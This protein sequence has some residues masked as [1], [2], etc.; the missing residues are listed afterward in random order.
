MSLDV[1]GVKIDRLSHEQVSDSLR[2][3]LLGVEQK[4]VVT[5]NPEFVLAAQDD[6]RFREILNEAHLSL[7][8]G[9]GLR[10][11]VSAIHDEDLEHRMTG[12]DT[13][14]H[15][16]QLC[17]ETKSRLMLFGGRGGSAGRA[18]AA[19][20]R[21]FP[22]LEVLGVEPG[23][24][25]S[26]DGEPVI[27]RS[28]IHKLHQFEPAV[29]AV[30]LGQIKQE[31]FLAKYL[32]EL[33]SVK[34]GIGVGGAFDMLAGDLKRAPGWMQSMGLEWLW[35][36]VI[37]PRRFARIWAA[38]VVFPLVVAWYTMRRRH[39]LR[40]CARVWPAVVKQLKNI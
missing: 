2:R 32:S 31:K 40:S 26:H 9:V 12:V 6:T 28:L 7:P 39:F 36:L 14:R 22:G 17:L 19:L 20:R 25:V 13:L 3:W 24:I 38:V 11:A 33:S 15:L 18:A 21:D 5:P 16:A 8:D 29:L 35:R 27:S 10:F 23:E 34:I 37:E 4:I 30:G 1:I